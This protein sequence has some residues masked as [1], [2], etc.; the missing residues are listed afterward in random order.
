MMMRGFG[1]QVTGMRVKRT[2]EGRLNLF[3]QPG[4]DKL[5]KLQGGNTAR[6]ETRVRVNGSNPLVVS[7]LL[8]Q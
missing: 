5:G 2:C 7:A 1:W 4:G 3:A 6:S 8:Y